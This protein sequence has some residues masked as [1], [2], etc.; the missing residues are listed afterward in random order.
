MGTKITV[1]MDKP[2]TILTKRKLN[3]DGKAQ[4][5]F[6]NQCAKYMNNYVPFLTGRLKDEDVEIGTNYV[7]YNAPYARKQ[8][9][10]NK[11][12]GKRNLSG[13]RGKLWDKKMWTYKGKEILKNLA[14][15]V[16]GKV[17]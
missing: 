1:K 15:Y 11:G 12:T 5:Y 10:T 17:K 3:K 2:K 16:G 4:V 8:Y 9:Y 7:K 14:N 6:T 13:L